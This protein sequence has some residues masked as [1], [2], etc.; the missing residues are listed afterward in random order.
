MVRV[1]W[2]GI[3]PDRVYVQGFHNTPLFLHGRWHPCRSGTK[4]A[5]EKHV[6]ES[7]ASRVKPYHALEKWREQTI[8]G[9]M[10]EQLLK[11]NC[12]CVSYDWRHSSRHATQ[13]PLIDYCNILHNNYSRMTVWSVL[14][15]YGVC[16]VHATV[17][18]E[19]CRKL[20]MA[21][22]WI[23]GWA[24]SRR[25]CSRALALVCSVFRVQMASFRRE[26]KTKTELTSC[27]VM[28]TS[29]KIPTIVFC[30]VHH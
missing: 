7:K 4:I 14:R 30:I 6:R 22:S 5:A 18:P 27:A 24:R 23:W 15:Y 1:H 20:L 25:T 8:K 16:W 28:Y 26:R 13:Y 19:R 29:S 3:R 11:R 12:S 10:K 17:R 2:T 9:S 21:C